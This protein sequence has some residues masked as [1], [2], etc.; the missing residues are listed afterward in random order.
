[1]NNPPVSTTV[2]LNRHLQNQVFESWKIGSSFVSS[3]TVA[4]LSS[5]VYQGAGEAVDFAHT[6]AALLCNHLF[7]S[8][9]RC[10]TVTAAAAGAGLNLSEVTVQLDGQQ[11]RPVVSTVAG[12]WQCFMLQQGSADVVACIAIFATA[13]LNNTSFTKPSSS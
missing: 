9:G 11:A 3:R 7:S 5:S 4:D 12:V 10:F 8:Q 6:K 2:Q 1:M 13:S